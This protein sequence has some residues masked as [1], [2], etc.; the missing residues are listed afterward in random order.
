MRKFWTIG[1]FALV[2]L[3]AASLAAASP[4]IALQEEQEQQEQ[5]QEQQEPEQE[6]QI[7]GSLQTVDLEAM[8]ITVA[9]GMG[10]ETTVVVSE[11][12]T[13]SGPDGPLTV[14]DLQGKEGSQ[15][16]VHVVDDGMGP[17]ALSI[18]LVAA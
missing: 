13:V 14:A 2:L 9:D 5:E 16:V 17:E 1:T 7:E 6:Q 10:S 4:F 8:Q 11:E 18:E 15:I 12:T 3:A